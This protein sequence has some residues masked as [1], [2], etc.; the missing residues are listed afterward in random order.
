MTENKNN[1]TTQ[2]YETPLESWKEIAVYLKRDVRTVIRWEKHEGLPVRR[3]L[4]QA[5]SSVYAYPSE[6][7]AWKAARQPGFDQAPL[8]MPWRRPIPALGFALTLLLALVSV[9]SGPIL[10]PP[11][12]LAQ[13]AGG[14]TARQVWSD[15]SADVFGG[16][17]ADGRYL[18]VVDWSTGDLALLDLT[19]GEQHRLTNKGPWSQSE[20]YALT[21]ALSPDG[22]QIAYAWFN[23]E[24]GFDLRVIGIDGSG[25]HV[26]YGNEETNFVHVAGWDPKGQSVLALLGRRDKTNQI[27]L[28][29][30]GDGLVQVLK[31]LDWRYPRAMSLSPDGRYVAYDFP[32]KENAPE[33]DIFLLATDGSRESPLVEHPSDDWVLGWAPGGKHVLFASDRT[34]TPGAWVVQVADGKPLG[35]PELVKPDLGRRIFPIGF[36]R[37]GSFFYDVHSG[38][39]DVYTATLDAHVRKVTAS[40]TPLR[41]R[42]IGSNGAPE[43][44]PGGKYLAYLSKRGPVLRGDFDTR[45]V[46]R[47]VP[48]GEERELALGLRRVIG[49]YGGIRW[50]PDGRS[51]SVVGQDTKGRYG[52]YRV[53]VQT[54]ATTPL[55]REESGGIVYWQAWAPDGQSLYFV[56]RDFDRKI[57][58]IVVRDLATGLEKEVFRTAWSHIGRALALSPD[59]R[60]LAFILSNPAA[61]STSLY[62][63]PAAGGETRELLNLEGPEGFAGNTLAWSR[64]GS[65]LL[66][67]KALESAGQDQK[68]ELW[69]IP[70]EGGEPQPLGLAM[71]G[72]R[73]LRVHPDGQ[74]IAFTAG[75]RKAELWVLENFLP[76]TEAQAPQLEDE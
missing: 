39:N 1:I 16:P 59:G 52:I 20:E 61:G 73:D 23:K 13:E 64:D 68:T 58:H 38:M 43:W 32:P 27:A 5:R 21:S 44:S 70:A 47:S 57:R 14:M 53:N 34:G 8:V 66:F 60:W 71:V 18:S 65:Q 62:V 55:A 49:V 26:I 25:P 36:T 10:T 3:H 50:A 29:R 31:T 12:A 17:S 54:G 74:R 11:G 6:L 72:L 37:N 33:R 19:T 76:K 22:K 9:A 48:T 7:E 75:K 63:V 24:F 67:G 46:I 4:H 51:L 69:R 28:V 42:F 40:P 56:R 45:I 2:I 15:P 41:Q 30:V 35:S